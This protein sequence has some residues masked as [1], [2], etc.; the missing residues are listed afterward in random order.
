MIIKQIMEVRDT[1]ILLR[2]YFQ[3]STPWLS[4]C[5]YV[6]EAL[7][8]GFWWLTDEDE[9]FFFFKEHKELALVVSYYLQRNLPVF[10]MNLSPMTSRKVWRKSL[11]R[12]SKE[13][14]KYIYIYIGLAIQ[15][16]PLRLQLNNVK[17]IV[18]KLSNVNFSHLRNMQFPWPT[19][20]SGLC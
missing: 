1:T 9:Y 7:I 6:L 16:S 14:K 4:C 18:W 2:K 19:G 12:T 8:V 3:T 15:P 10:R 13:L 20:V 11:T 5:F 17:K